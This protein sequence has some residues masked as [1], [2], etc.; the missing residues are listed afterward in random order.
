VRDQV[1]ISYSQDDLPWLQKLHTHL[2]PFERAHKIEVWDDTEIKAGA[3]R[4]EEIEKALRSAKVA[5]LLV[6]PNFLASDF[7]AAHELSP[8]LAAAEA[9]GLTIIWV[10]VSASAYAETAI[11]HYEPANDPAQPL[12]SL[13]P[14]KLN[15]ELVRICET[16]KQAVTGGHAGATGGGRIRVRSGGAT[17]AAFE[18]QP[19]PFAAPAVSKRTLFAA[20]AGLTLVVVIAGVF[21]YSRLGRE[22][23][24]S[25]PP[26]APPPKTREL[27]TVELDDD[28]LDLSKWEHAP[29]FSIDPNDGQGRLVV[30][31]Q[32]QVGTATGIIYENF[33]LH[34]NLKLLNEGGAAWALRVD[35]SKGN[36]YLFYLS[37]PKGKYPNRFLSYIVRDGVIDEKTRRSNELIGALEA[38]AQY[39]V[40]V[41]ANQNKITHKITPA[42]NGVE[43]RMH[44]FV[45]Q[46]NSYP[47]GGL[48]FRTVGA[49]KFSIDDLLARPLDIR[50]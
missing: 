2:K 15:E 40:D 16:I 32:P 6:S 38:G 45:D 44:E 4:H 42:S 50:N 33:E 46:H 7:I 5:V 48:G 22:A 11:K 8:L 29:G 20:I 36:Y 41:E 1:F 21:A 47:R 3:K 39:Y 26:A 17:P 10:A 49:E 35:E 12:D 18:P 14:A 43:M 30:E 13:N 28:F 24:K 37:G 34:F 23:V 9:E 19:S 25:E 31:G 27:T